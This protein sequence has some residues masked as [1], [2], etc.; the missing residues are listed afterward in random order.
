MQSGSQSCEAR[1]AGGKQ[2]MMEHMRRGVTPLT[3]AIANTQPTQKT[4][5]WQQTSAGCV[6][7]I[8][9]QGADSKRC[10]LHHHIHAAHVLHHT[11]P[12]ILLLLLLLLLLRG[13]SR[14]AGSVRVR[15]EGA[16]PDLHSISIAR[17][18]RRTT[19][20]A[21]TLPRFPL[22]RGQP[23]TT[24]AAQKQAKCRHQRIRTPAITQ[25]GRCCSRHK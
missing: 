11:T 19:I 20:S 24:R 14:C 8:A 1:Y 3:P 4:G 21:P 12:L 17:T 7:C 16:V 15:N 2:R 9:Q 18:C 10:L 25:R 5:Q 6:A 23:L 13:V 22:A